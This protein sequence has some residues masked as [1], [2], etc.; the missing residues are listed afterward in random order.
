MQNLNQIIF[1]K[2]QTWD[3]KI[4]VFLK[5]ETLWLSQ[6]M[7]AEP[8]WLQENNVT[9]HFKRNLSFMRIRK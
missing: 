7:M 9:Y 3:I 5:Y 6:K 2:S 1:Y 4:N 8:F